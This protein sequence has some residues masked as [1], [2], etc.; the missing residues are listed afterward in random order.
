VLEGV[1]FALRSV[2]DVMDEASGPVET[3]MVIGGGARGALFRRILADVFERPLLVPEQLETATALGAAAAAAVGVGL[4][5][6]YAECARWVRIAH[7]EEPDPGRATIYR[8]SHA[9]YQAL[10][11]AL[12]E[13]FKYC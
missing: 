5:S 13:T 9:R 2:L 8:E 7:T 1:A 6:S 4:R 10:Y 12:K 11:P 3:M